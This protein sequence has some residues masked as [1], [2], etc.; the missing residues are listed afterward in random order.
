MQHNSDRQHRSLLAFPWLLIAGAVCAA[1]VIRAL[2]VQ[3]YLVPSGSMQPTL[4]VGDRV[5]IEKVSRWWTAPSRGDVVAFDG[6]DVWGSA[7]NGQMLAKRVIGV[8]GDHVLCCDAEGRVRVNG[9]AV[10]EPYA[11]GRSAAFDITVPAGRLWLLGDDRAHSEDSRLF[12]HTPGQGSVPVSHVFGRV[13]GVVWPL[14]R[15][16]I[17]GQP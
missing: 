9:Q 1:L 2:A 14:S 16:G 15:A 6:T 3:V 7:A 11:S 12:L 13:V 17:L 5:L 8:A 4:D 10:S